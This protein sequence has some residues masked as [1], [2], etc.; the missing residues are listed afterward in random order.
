MYGSLWRRNV[1]GE[2]GKNMKQRVDIVTIQL[3]FV[4]TAAALYLTNVS[5]FK[6]SQMF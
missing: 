5:G 6:K 4:Q 3:L 1:V 2:V